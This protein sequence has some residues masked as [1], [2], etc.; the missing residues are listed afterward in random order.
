MEVEAVDR[1]R[2]YF[3]G[4]A[5]SSPNIALFVGGRLVHMLERLDIEGRMAAEIA[6]ELIAAF[7]QHCPKA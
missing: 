6:A 3:E 7:D 2:S 5:P 4:Y 1:V